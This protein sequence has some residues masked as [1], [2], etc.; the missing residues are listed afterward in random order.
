M[1]W[2]QAL[3]GLGSAVVVAIGARQAK[4]LSHS[5]MLAAML[6]GALHFGLGGLGPAMLLIAFFLSSSLL[7]RLGG[8]RKKLVQTS[9]AK[10]GERDAR[11]VLA[12]GGLSSLCAVLY[13]IWPQ[14]FWLAGLAGA[15]AA[16][17]SD[18]W[19]TELGVLSRRPPRRITDLKPAPRGASGAVSPL[20]LLASL[21][22]A[23]LIAG[24]AGLL[25]PGLDLAL[26]ALAGGFSGSLFDSIL[27]ASV[28]AIHYCPGCE[29]DT[30]RH[31]LHTC[32]T[33]THHLRGWR[34]LDN[35]GVNAA[36]TAMG[37]AISIGLSIIR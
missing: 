24:L 21:C 6:V 14:G 13:A 17:N 20:G 5:G 12:N 22:G 7:S 28:Q 9:F 19:A 2:Y 15:L 31:P 4:A 34:W 36:A 8:E 1:S 32:G 35:D 26:A 29:R 23:A 16:A 25:S 18:T 33:E 27:G 30:E 37:A 11:Q 3:I 10:G